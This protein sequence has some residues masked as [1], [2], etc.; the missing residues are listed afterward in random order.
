MTPLERV[1]W[2]NPGQD[3]FEALAVLAQKDVN[4][5][6]VI[7]NGRVRGLV[8]RE[9]ILKWLSLYGK[10]DGARRAADERHIT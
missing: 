6:P 7:E 9:D 8:R 5:V 3:A 2:L 4:Q 10:G 1:T